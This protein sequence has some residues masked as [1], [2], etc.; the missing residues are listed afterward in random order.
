MQISAA[1]TGV[2]ETHLETNI[3]HQIA[4]ITLAKWK[5]FITIAPL[6]TTVLEMWN[7]FPHFLWN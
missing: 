7:C 2:A 3:K 5:N 4:D 6:Y 1:K